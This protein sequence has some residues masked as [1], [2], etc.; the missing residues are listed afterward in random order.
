MPGRMIVWVV[1]LL[2]LTWLFT[3]WCETPLIWDGAYQLAIM[4][5][6]Q[7][8]YSFEGRFHSYILWLPVVPLSRLTDNVHI[9]QLV[10]GL[11]FAMAPAAGVAMSWWIVRKERPELMIW[12]IFGI[13]AATLPGQIFIIND[14]IFQ[15]HLFWPL[16][17]AVFVRVTKAQLVV[18]LFLVI[19]QFS[20]AIGFILLSGAAGCALLLS[21]V[22]RANRKR[23]LIRTSLFSLLAIG[24]L[25]KIYL[26]PDSYAATEATWEKAMERWDKGVAGWPARGL[27]MM[28][29][30][31]AVVFGAGILGREIPA[32]IPSPSAITST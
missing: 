30:S 11:P 21:L 18:L 14:S 5:R 19:F 16:F 9:L 7:E 2:G 32:R 22:D 27:W 3:C 25:A 1:A 24:A 15:Q 4:L 6:I 17:M 20:H 13:A 12:P 29:M 26:V 23:L 10:Y 28:W 31:G 8:P